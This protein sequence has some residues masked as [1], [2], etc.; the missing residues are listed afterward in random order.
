MQNSF[1]LLLSLSRNLYHD[2]A[3]YI[4]AWEIFY[5]LRSLAL[6][7]DFM[8][9][10][11]ILGTAEPPFALV[12]HKE[13]GKWKDVEKNYDTYFDLLF[14]N[15][16]ILRM[17]L[18]CFENCSDLLWEEIL[19]VTKKCFCKFDAEGREFANF[20]DEDQEQVIWIVKGQNSLR[21]RILFQLASWVFNHV[22]YI[23]TIK[24]PFGTNI[25]NVE[26]Y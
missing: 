22:F 16:H 6:N 24:M 14:L 1:V 9:R 2:L 19:L 21:S 5:C 13:S 17:Y 8:N 25:W 15:N 3:I 4:F 10:N 7:H 20:L 26:T 12:V 18:F 23:G 11:G